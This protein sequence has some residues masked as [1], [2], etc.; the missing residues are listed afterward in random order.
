LAKRTTGV[1]EVRSNILS[2]FPLD[3]GWVRQCGQYRER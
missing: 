2:P 3:E 1:V